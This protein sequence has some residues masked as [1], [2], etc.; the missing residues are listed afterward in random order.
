MDTLPTSIGV[1]KRRELD[2]ACASLALRDAVPFD[3]TGLRDFIAAN[4]RT[5]SRIDFNGVE[6]G[7]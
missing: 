6:L 5:S 3:R 7:Q 2:V 4:G 1:S